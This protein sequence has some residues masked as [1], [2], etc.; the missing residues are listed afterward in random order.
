MDP[1]L[2]DLAG[3]VEIRAFT[4]LHQRSG[5]QASTFANFSLETCLVYTPSE[6]STV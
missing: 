2:H 6:S 4:F 1:I 3:I 5:V